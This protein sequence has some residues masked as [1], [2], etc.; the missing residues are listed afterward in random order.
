MKKWFKTA[1][2]YHVF[3]DRFA[4]F[5]TNCNPELAEFCGGNLRAIIN[6]LAYIKS[7][8]ANT[9][10]LSP[11]YETSAYHG[12]HITNFNKVDP[13]YGTLDDLELLIQDC[14]QKH[15]KIIADIVP[16]HCSIFHPWFVNAKN[17]K[18]SKYKQWFYF[19]K[20]PN[21]YLN[22][23][24]FNELPKLNL[25]NS[26]TADW[27]INNLVSWANIG[28]DGFRIDHVLGIPDNF[29]IKLKQ[30]LSELNPDF[31]LI[32]EAW[33]EGMK[34]KSLKTI[35]LRGRYKLWKKGFS[36]VNLQKHYEGI[37]DG[38]LD[39][40]WRNL[41]L[42]NLHVIQKNPE[43]LLNLFE[44]YNKRFEK[45]FFLPRFLDNHDTSRIMHLC[46]NNHHLF[47]NVLKILF[48][49]NQ[50]IVLYYGTESGLHPKQN[51]DENTPYSDLNARGIINW[52]LDK[53]KFQDTIKELA[54]LRQDT[55]SFSK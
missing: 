20:W 27:M 22:F 2:I 39:F 47:R 12:Y 23:L 14:K 6:K 4:G 11:F 3:I 33:G 13:S 16:N 55:Q 10:W 37:L 15:I 46:N 28:F 30:K 8:G 50:P 36:Q 1:I 51:V 29:L 42:E 45:D 44:S 48:K 32:G 19:K 26:E 9:I 24:G 38:V 40:G 53:Q 31:V 52:E 54:I 43:K 34:H 35:R 21:E 18:N 7:L 17:N 49:Q 25:E 5:K 41:L